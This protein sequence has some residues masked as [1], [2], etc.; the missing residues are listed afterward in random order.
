MR[1]TKEI[2][3]EV[4]DSYVIENFYISENPILHFDKQ[5]YRLMHGLIFIFIISGEAVIHTNDKAY[6]VNK[7][8]LVSIVPFKSFY[9]TKQSK[10]F[11]Y[12]YIA[13]KIDF[14]ADFPLMLQP[15]ISEMI[16]KTPYINLNNDSFKLIEG[17]YRSILYQYKRSNHPSRVNMIKANLYIFVAELSFIY[18]QQSSNIICTHQEQITD[19]FLKLLHT[20]YRVERKPDFYANKMCMSTKYLSRVLKK[21]TGLTLYTWICEFV[22]K[23]SKILLSS[24]DMSIMQISDKLNFPN[25]SYFARYFRKYTSMSPS[26][27]RER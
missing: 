24:S 1:S 5:Q 3:M 14:M 25:S 16:E 13:F 9:I 4:I 6:P 15:Y 18:S 11:R 12:E 2:V 17:Y 10:E 20:F 8:M 7:N 26:K 23:E 19:D 22:I 27:F 21:V